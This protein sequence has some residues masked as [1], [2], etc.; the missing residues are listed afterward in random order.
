MSV[1]R[2]WIDGPKKW[3]PAISVR[4][5]SLIAAFAERHVVLTPGLAARLAGLE[6]AD[7]PA[8]VPVWGQAFRLAGQAVGQGSVVG[9]SRFW[10]GAVPVFPVLVAEPVLRRAMAAFDGAGLAGAADLPQAPAIARPDRWKARFDEMVQRFLSAPEIMGRGFW[11]ETAVRL[12]AAAWR[13]AQSRAGRTPRRLGLNAVAPEAD[14]LLCRLLFEAEPEFPESYSLDSRRIRA[15]EKSQRKRA[16]HRPKEGGVS[17]IRTST[18]L[19][20]LPDVLI[21]ELVLPPRLV[22]DRLLHEGLIVRH[23]PPYRQ[24]KRDLLILG[25]ADRRSDGAAGAIAK[26][27]WADA[28]I[29]LQILLGQ[30]GL[31][32][33]ELVWSEARATGIA[34]DL[35]R[36]EDAEASVGLDPSLL[37][38][39]LRAARLFRSG[40][41]PGFPDTTGAT[42]PLPTDA[43]GVGDRLLYLARAGLRRLQVRHRI[44][45]GRLGPGADIAHRPAD[46]GRRVA[47]VVLPPGSELALRAGADWTGVRGQVS[48]TLA[49]V[50]E[51]N[52]H[53]IGLLPPREVAPGA[54]FAVVGD[55]IPGG[56][57]EAVLDPDAPAADA[58]NRVLGTLSATLILAVLGALDAG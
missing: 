21:S 34:A 45:S 36:V 33:S 44:G 35:L 7:A 57:V 15:R 12:Q 6:T 51:E 11:I 25:L 41:M 20:D 28:A 3:D 5:A 31:P 1:P 13:D 49:R 48:A 54:S 4:A 22:V 39:S 2:L 9:R 52:T 10:R 47:I 27:A 8:D 29:R 32:L 58:V 53:L 42:D 37:Q 14:P 17:G 56:L 24:P 23:R 26:A 19:D 18:N 40:L 50:M 55:L 46:Y 30:M 16:G 38:G 43:D